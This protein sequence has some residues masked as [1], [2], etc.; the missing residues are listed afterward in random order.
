[1]SDPRIC[2]RCLLFESGRNDVL[3]DIRL[4]IEKIPESDR[5]AQDMYRA[6]LAVCTACDQL[7]D[8]TFEKRGYKALILAGVEAGIASIIFFCVG[9]MD[10]GV[11]YCC[12]TIKAV[13]NRTRGV[14]GSENTYATV[15][16]AAR[17]RHHRN[18]LW[19]SST[20]P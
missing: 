15:S 6:R 11:R 9:S 16:A 1:M 2:R 17:L 3:A 4:H 13:M 12:S 18:E 8:G 7:A 5:C 19:R 20:A 10:M 14:I